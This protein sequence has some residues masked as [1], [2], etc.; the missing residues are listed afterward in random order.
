MKNKAV[1]CFFLAVLASGC[2]KSSY[3]VGV[4]FSSDD[5]KK[6]E[7]GKTET[8]ELVMLFGEPF[9]KVVLSETDEKWLY[10]HSS[11]TANVQSY[12]ITANIETKGIQKTLDILV[13]NGVVI[14]YTYSEGDTAINV[15]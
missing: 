14:N 8:S 1:T 5:V 9:S 10:T 13:R 15:N 4:D 3:T 7:K 12:I 6:I 2:A 11:G